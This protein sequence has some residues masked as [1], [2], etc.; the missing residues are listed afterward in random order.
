[1]SQP[2][3]LIL[4]SLDRVSEIVDDPSA[5]VYERLFETYPDFKKLFRF[6]GNGDLARQN[7]FQVTVVAL[8]EHLEGRA[9]SANIVKTERMNHS[10]IGVPNADFDRYYEVVRDTFRDILGDE[11]TPETQ[12]AWD[13]AIAGLI[14][15]TPYE[16]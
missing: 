6:E 8:M 10:H 13:E 15:A 14:S 4:E 12:A 2:A 1:M 16:G 7:M 11:W 9:A 3:E 5:P